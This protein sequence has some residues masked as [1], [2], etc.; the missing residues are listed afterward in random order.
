LIQKKVDQRRVPTANVVGDGVAPQ[1]GS[2]NGAENELSP[3]FWIHIPKTGTSLINTLILN[4]QICPLWTEHT[5]EMNETGR[6]T[7]E[8]TFRDAIDF[9]A[10]FGISPMDAAKEP[11]HWD[12]IVDETC[13][14]GFFY[15]VEAWGPMS[16]GVHYPVGHVWDDLESHGSGVVMIRQPEQRFLSDYLSLFDHLETRPGHFVPPTLEEAIRANEGCQLRFFTRE[17]KDFCPDHNNSVLAC[18]SA[19]CM[20]LMAPVT[21]DEVVLAKSRLRSLA[22]VGITDQWDLS[23]CL[24]N[25]M[26]NQTCKSSQFA[27]LNPTANTTKTGSSYDTSVLEGYTDPYDGALYDEALR[28]FNENLNRY[29]VTEVSCKEACPRRPGQ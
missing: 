18:R 24:W 20:P 21:S 22:F 4:R 12:P 23:M 27:N 11:G 6:L 7:P 9:R 17:W 29:N 19:H 13:P 25:A 1:A 15:S 2:R 5:D 28:I 16:I 3:V 8:G 14:N 26:F 10:V